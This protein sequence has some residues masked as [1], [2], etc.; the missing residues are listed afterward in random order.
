MW[1]RLPASIGETGRAINRSSDN[2]GPGVFPPYTRLPVLAESGSEQKQMLPGS[3]PSLR[4]GRHPSQKKHDIIIF[5]LSFVLLSIIIPSYLT[6]I[7]GFFKLH[8]GA[9]NHD[10]DVALAGTGYPGDFPVRQTAADH[11]RQDVPLGF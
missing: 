3:C 7:D 6:G 9:V 5:F 8:A 1:E 4:R 2:R 10:L 11:Q